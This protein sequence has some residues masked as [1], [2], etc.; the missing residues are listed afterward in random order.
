MR[1]AP[2]HGRAGTIG[3]VSGWYIAFEGPEGSGKSTVAA[4]IAA[5]I[6]AVL[7]RETGGTPIGQRIRDILHDVSVDHL[8]F[9]AE[10]L[11]TA[12]DRAQHL[13]QIVLPALNDGRHVVSDRSVYSTL[14]Y[15]GY[16]RGL[17]LDEI[18]RINDWAVGGR[19]PDL[20]ILIDADPDVIAERL[21]DRQLDRFERQD[22]LFHQRVA[23]GFR[24]LAAADPQRWAVIDGAEPLDDVVDAVRRTVRE[25]LGI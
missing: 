13:E 20:V 17:E 2:D 12:A 10:A 4:R 3:R 16:G 21:R 25:R 8:A 6:G 24:Q 14:S 7:T 23:E 18:R 9:R 15:Q 19:W 11:L 22:H 5:Q 1:P